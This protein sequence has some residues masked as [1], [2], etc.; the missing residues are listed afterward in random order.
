MLERDG[1]TPLNLGI[2]F[3]GD[4]GSVTATDAVPGLATWSAGVAALLMLL[5]CGAALRARSPSVRV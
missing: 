4:E 3:A 1:S 5:L 2:N